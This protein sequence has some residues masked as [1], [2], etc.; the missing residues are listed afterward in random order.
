LKIRQEQC[1]ASQ[2]CGQAVKK[3]VPGSEGAHRIGRFGW[4]DQHASLLAFAADAYLNEMGITSS[5]QKTALTTIC[6]PPVTTTIPNNDPSKITEP[7]SLTDPNDNSLED[8]DHFASFIRSLKAP[9]R[10][11]TAVAKPDSQTKV[12]NYSPRL[13]AQGV[14]LKPS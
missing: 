5:L 3:P 9:P 2:I 10:E 11:E 12:R 4:K 13:V 1:R 8:I 7:N 14:V 6:H